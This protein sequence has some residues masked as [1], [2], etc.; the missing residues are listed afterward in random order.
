MHMTDKRQPCEDGLC[1]GKLCFWSR[2]RQAGTARGSQLKREQS[3][4]ARSSGP[5]R[6]WPGG[7]M[8]EARV[9]RLELTWCSGR[10][11]QRSS[12]GSRHTGDELENAVP[13]PGSCAALR[14]PG[15][16]LQ[17]L[18]LATHE[19]SIPH[20]DTCH[21]VSTD[22]SQREHREP[23]KSNSSVNQCLPP[24]LKFLSAC[25]KSLRGKVGKVG[26]REK[27]Q[28]PNPSLQH[29]LSYRLGEERKL[30]FRPKLDTGWDFFYTRKW[31]LM[32]KARLFS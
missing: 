16:P 10:T 15:E 7:N 32:I 27:C 6:R 12:S 19:T 23:S 20:A 26:G 9:P 14:T 13:S 18:T 1:S 24:F 5:R 31:D 4:G 21:K 8:F 28:T 22:H 11:P 17:E 29:S 25:S 30:S 2:Q 3:V